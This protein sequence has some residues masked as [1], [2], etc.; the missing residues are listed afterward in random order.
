MYAHVRPEIGPD[1]KTR[2]KNIWER[3][4]CTAEFESLIQGSL[5]KNTKHPKK[6]SKKGRI[7]KLISFDCDEEGDNISY[8]D[9]GQND[10]E[11]DS[12]DEK[13]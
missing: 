7:A 10:F 3:F 6:K 5:G 9:E 12:N 1:G 2:L 8:G 4:N 11:V 13:V